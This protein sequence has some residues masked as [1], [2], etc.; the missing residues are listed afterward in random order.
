VKPINRSIKV[1]GYE[2]LPTSH[3]ALFVKMIVK[4]IAGGWGVHSVAKLRLVLVQL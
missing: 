4:E 2:Y 3:S 1:D